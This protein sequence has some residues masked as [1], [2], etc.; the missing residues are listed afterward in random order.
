MLLHN[1]AIAL[2]LP[3]LMEV[4]IEKLEREAKAPS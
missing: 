1:S 2:S 3:W 4:V